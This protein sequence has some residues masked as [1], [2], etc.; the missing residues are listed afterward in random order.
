MGLD[1]LHFV[2]KLNRGHM[3]E[4][5]I[6]SATDASLEFRW[7]HGNGDTEMIS[8]HPMTDEEF[9]KLQKEYPVYKSQDDNLK[10]YIASYYD[11]Y[12]MLSVK[13]R[14]SG[15]N[16]SAIG[17]NWRFNASIDF[18]LPSVYSV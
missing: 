3:H 9:L 5:E 7:E 12:I 14:R 13:H 8:V 11:E 6:I 4:G 18:I 2:Y 17:Y 10:D 16:S 1:A 15:L